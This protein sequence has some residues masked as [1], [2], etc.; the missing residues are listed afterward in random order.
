VQIELAG[1]SIRLDNRF[2]E[3]EVLCR[4]Y[5][6]D[7][8]PVIVLAVTQEEIEAE[9]AKQA[10]IFTDGYLETVCLY[11][12]LALEMLMLNIFLIHA[13][14]IEVDGE[15]YAFLAHSGTG[16]TTQTRL[17]LEYF[18]DHARVI[19]GDKPLIRAVP[20]GTGWE[21]VAFGTPWCGKEGMGC[22]ASVPLKALFLLER[23]TVP[24]CEPA[25]QEYSIDRLFHQLLMPEKPEQ[26]M[27]LLDMVDKLV[28]TVP[29]YRLRCDMTDASVAA[30][31]GAATKKYS[32][33]CGKEET[34]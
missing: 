1:I 9:R 22:N 27:L 30:A 32:A 23:A 26:M 4:D 5:Q 18:G 15:G 29:C 10:D 17:W 14:V 19:N 2:P 13:S 16:K 7:K 24:T 3:L 34:E 6:T 25:D 28:E 12:K 20:A 31:Y 8:A 21:F 33:E 11:R